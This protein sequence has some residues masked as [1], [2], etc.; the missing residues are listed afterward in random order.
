[1]NRKLKDFLIYRTPLGVARALYNLRIKTHS[2]SD[3]NAILLHLTSRISHPKTFVEFGFHAHEFNCIGLAKTYSGLLIDGDERSVALARKVLPSQIEAVA[4]FLTLESLSMI[5]ERFPAGTLGILSID[6]DGND[7]W[8]LERL[9]ALRPAI[10]SVEYNASFGLRPVTVV[11]DPAFVRHDKHS[12]GWYHGASLTALTYLCDKHG[13][14]LAAVS[15]GGINAF[16]VRR[17][18]W[19]ADLTKLLPEK[20]FRENKFRN[21]WSDTT[22]E[23]QWHAVRDLPFVSVGD[24]IGAK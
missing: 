12:R 7:Y 20:A 21:Q 10:I 1:M 24:G 16:F 22:A 3:E 19:S 2:Q 23:A 11:Y 4:R 13:Y 9:I 8:F 6:V 18:L 5:E 15:E 14:D 17:D